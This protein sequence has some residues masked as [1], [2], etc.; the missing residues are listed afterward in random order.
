MYACNSILFNHESTHRGET[1]VTRKITSGIANI[2][3]VS[4][5]YLHLGNMAALRDWDHVKDYVR[6]DDWPRFRPS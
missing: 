1:F 4:D 5:P 3:L 6:R 2:A